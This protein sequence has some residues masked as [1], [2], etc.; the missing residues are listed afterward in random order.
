M[1]AFDRFD[2]FD[3]IEQRVMAAIDEIAAPRRPEYLDDILGLTAST[4]QR[5]RWAFRGLW[6]P[7]RDTTSSARQ[8]ARMTTRS[9]V[10]LVVIALLAIAATAILVAGSRPRLPLPVGLAVNGAILFPKGGDIYL[11]DGIADGGTE[12]PVI[13]GV[14]KQYAP[15]LSPDGRRFIYV[16]A[17]EG[18]DMAWVS[19]IDGSNRHQ[20]LPF[21]IEEGWSQW[22]WALDS[23]HILISGVFE[24]GHKRLYDVRT[25]GSGASEL[26]FEGLTPWEAF[27]SP[28]DPN[29]FLLRAQRVAGVRS[30]DLYLADADGG[31]LRPLH[32]TGGQSGFGPEMTLAGAAW[33]PDGRT[34][35]YNAFDNDPVTLHTSFRVHLVNPDGTDDR[36][37]PA[38]D[39]PNIHQ[40]WPVFSPDGTRIL[41]QRFILPTDGLANGAG[42]IAVVPADGTGPGRDIGRR[43]DATEDPDV[44]KVWSPDGT[45]VLEWAAAPGRAYLVDVETGVATELAGPD[46]LPDWQRLA[47]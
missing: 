14:T 6:L 42:W 25:D 16:E 11:R 18:G 41:V 38:P 24:G 9:I 7:F 19:D 10:L 43:V 23:A 22:S 1:T 27:W 4:S 46:D 13:T 20:V 34:I 17:V 5:P 37:L 40:A 36:V 15:M 2:P 30:H 47:R 26:T 33:A 45:K 44:V 21:P 12:T 31:N 39:D 29:T 35:A 32:L 8:P 3:P 28:T